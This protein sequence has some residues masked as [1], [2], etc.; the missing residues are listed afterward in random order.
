MIK[1]E[2]KEQRHGLLINITGSGKGKTSSAL[3]VALRALGWGWKVAAVQFIKDETETGERRFAQN[4]GMTFELCSS[5]AGFTWRNNASREEDITCCRHGWE[6]AKEYLRQTKPADLLILDEFNIVLAKELLP[7]D[8]I[9]SELQQR[10][11]W[12]HVIITGRNA[13]ERL[14]TISD[15]VSEIKDVKHPFREGIPAQ[16]GI[17]F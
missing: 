3:G 10:P 7:F 15:L 1:N 17:D 11:P 2:N 8:E 12:L 14:I 9:I 13:P 16:R 6:K 5:G 4:C